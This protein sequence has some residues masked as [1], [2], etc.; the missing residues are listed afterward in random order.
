MRAA[1]ARFHW[2]RSST[3][4]RA[5]RSA[6]CAPFRAISL[7]GA[8]TVRLPHARGRG[9][10]EGGSGV[11]GPGGGGAAGRG[12]GRAVVWRGVVGRLTACALGAVYGARLRVHDLFRL[13]PLCS[14]ERSL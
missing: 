8:W 6:A 5:F 14:V 1:S 4:A 10:Q 11:G 2:T 13:Q 9:Q 7:A 3:S 12:V